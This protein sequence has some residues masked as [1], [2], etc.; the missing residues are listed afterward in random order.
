MAVIASR[1][2]S[3][4]KNL[5]L[6]HAQLIEDYDCV[7]GNYVAQEK[8]ADALEIL[9][10]APW[11]KTEQLLYKCAPVLMESEPEK[12]AEVFLSKGRQEGWDKI[13]ISKLLP[14]CYATNRSSHLTLARVGNV[15]MHCIFCRRC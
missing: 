13:Q 3:S 6:C 11:E 14:R 8:F 7:V 10:N 1:S 12:A 4:T 5:L 15:I 2:E 9:R